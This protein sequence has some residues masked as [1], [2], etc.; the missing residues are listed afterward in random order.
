MSMHSIKGP[1]PMDVTYEFEDV[2]SEM[3]GLGTMVHI[4]VR[5]EASGFFKVATPFLISSGQTEHH[6]GPQE[7]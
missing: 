5:G 2:P 1:F 4:R 6:Q 7:S 3:V